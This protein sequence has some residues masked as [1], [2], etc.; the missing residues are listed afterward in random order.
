M[1]TDAS[2]VQLAGGTGMAPTANI[3]AVAAAL[4]DPK[5]H[6]ADLGGTAG[7]AEL[8]SAVLHRMET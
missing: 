7:T 8:G 5:H 3:R 6:T 1:A 2:T 4:R